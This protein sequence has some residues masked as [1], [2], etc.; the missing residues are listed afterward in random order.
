M[1]TMNHIDSGGW[2]VLSIVTT[3]CSLELYLYTSRRQALPV[4]YDNPYHSN[5]TAHL[6]LHIKFAY[7]DLHT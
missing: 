1:I 6:N 7:L 5:E 4:C 3:A 2:H